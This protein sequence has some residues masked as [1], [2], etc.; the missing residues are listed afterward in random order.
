LIALILVVGSISLVAA[1]AI[2]LPGSDSGSGTALPGLPGAQ[3]PQT[4]SAPGREPLDPS[5]GTTSALGP[6]APGRDFADDRVL[7][8]FERGADKGERQDALESVDATQVAAY[9]Q[10]AV[11][12]LEGSTE[13]EEAVGTLEANPDVQFAEPDF[14]RGLDA[15][16]DCWHLNEAPGANVAPVVK[17]GITGQGSVVAVVDTGVDTSLSDLSG[18]VLGQRACT[19]S[20]CADGG[21]GGVHGTMVASVIAAKDDD[22][23]TTGVAPGARVKSWKVDTGGSSP[24]IPTSYVLAALGEI[25]ADPSVDIVNMSF[26]GEQPSEAEQLAVQNLID[27]GKTV[28]ASAGNDGSYVP[29]YPAAYPGVISVGATDRSGAVAPWS[30]FGKVDVVAPGSCIPVDAMAGAGTDGG[31]P[32]TPAAGTVRATGTSFS[33]PLVAGVLA[34]RHTSSTLRTR[35]ALYGTATGIAGLSAD[36][37]KPRGHG[38][39]DA[40]ALDASFADDAPPYMVLEAD[41]QIPHP[42]TTFTTWVL[43]TNGKLTNLPSPASFSG[44]SDG[45]SSFISSEA[46]VFAATLT[47][48]ALPAGSQLLNAT[49]DVATAD[50]GLTSDAT[51]TTSTA[52]AT[53]TTAPP[54]TTTPTTTTDSAKTLA[55][56][57]TTTTQAPATSTTAA[58]EGGA[59]TPD[60]AP[61]TTTTEP[62]ATPDAAPA[63][64]TTEP[65][66]T[67]DAAPSGEAAA[68][69]DAVEAPATTAA[70]MT[71]EP[72]RSTSAL[73]EGGIVHTTASVP[74]RVLRT[75]DQAPGS[76]LFA[77]AAATP[78]KRSDSVT[79]GGRGATADIDV[80]DVWSVALD[81]GDTI[82]SVLKPP[83]GEAIRVALYSPGTD[84]VFG[85]WDRIVASGGAAAADGSMTVSYT[86]TATGTYY[87]DVYALGFDS[88]APAAGSYTLTTTVSGSGS[89][90]ALTAPACSPN[91]DG[92]GELC[93]WSVNASNVTANV[94]N[95]AG[96]VLVTI[97]GAG[98]QAWDGTSSTGAD[99]PDGSYPLRIT[100]TSGGR[101]LSYDEALTLDRVAPTM[102]GFAASPNPFEPVP[103]DG[104]RDTI[105][106]SVNSSERAL[107]RV[108]VYDTNGGRLR[109]T[110]QASSF[111]NAGR[112]A[113][114]WDGVGGLGEQLAR[115]TYDVLVHVIDPAGNRVGSSRMVGA[116][117]IN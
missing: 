5:S 44:L 35:L 9:G 61:A 33:S 31:C 38:L 101:I 29:R 72:I 75:D 106:F 114:T 1:R 109:K 28:V 30:S 76:P 15:C 41:D 103:D 47:S 90:V 108:Y 71:T 65:A 7:I 102:S 74:V 57:A 53:T 97:K 95:K 46:G 70:T 82:R 24:S 22:S 34:L 93:R 110:V 36:L 111:Q 89:P 20:S 117:S 12:E 37:A 51:G 32:G 96:A 83:V 88:G 17:K 92:Y 13:V 87:L 86:A 48:G 3:T 19:A 69:P 6:A 54:S 14:Q 116:I 104:D 67:P 85:Q 66:A 81:Q 107:L 100:A 11:A 94:M 23:G 4:T 98:D 10:T 2:G 105:T 64:T 40:T 49:A 113:V 68:G 50:L 115:G 63:T 73:I 58:P 56:V 26:S 18:Q 78:W 16:A 59:A 21:G 39:V 84:N 27:K 55:G 62:A 99:Q 42:S 79:G 25:A 77:N 43:T 52:D 91:G 60:A 80:D 45:L 8:R 112:I